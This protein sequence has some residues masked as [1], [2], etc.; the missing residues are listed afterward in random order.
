LTL[1]HLCA[2][3]ERTDDIPEKPKTI[4]KK[5]VN[6]L[7]EEWD[8]QRTIKRQSKYARFEVDRKYEFLC[9]LAYVLTVTRRQT[10]FSSADIVYLYG[11]ICDQFGL[12]RN[13]AKE[14]AAELETHNGLLLQTGYEQFEFAHKS[15]QEF[16]TAE[17][18][19]KLPTIPDWG[20][21]GRLPYETAIAVAISSN[22][23]AYL[24]ELVFRRFR[25]RM[26]ENFIRAFLSRLIIEKPDLGSEAPLQLALL[27]LLS[28]YLDLS[29]VAEGRPWTYQG[30]RM[31]LEW[32]RMVKNSYS[33]TLTDILNCY[34][35]EQIYDTRNPNLIHRLTLHR[36]SIPGPL[37][38]ILSYFPRTLFVRTSLLNFRGSPK[39]GKTQ[40]ANVKV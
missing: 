21:L 8:L 4:Y 26:S 33:T 20:M 37:Q 10:V 15:L 25:T 34:S 28:E 14:V 5:I 3:Y 32:E 2:I 30:D 24:S 11:Q 6:L 23:G 38:S 36:K 7:L 39:Q 35:T 19:V 9:N 27:V 40:R 31:L 1:A 29:F 12:D 22:P 17:Y 16:L 18:L 13:E